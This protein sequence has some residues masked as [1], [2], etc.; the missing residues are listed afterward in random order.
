MAD[1]VEI[2]SQDVQASLVLR[3]SDVDKFT[4]KALLDMPGPRMVFD[5]ETMAEQAL[6]GFAK[7]AVNIEL[8][9]LEPFGLMAEASIPRF[10]DYS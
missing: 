10:E 3:A 5:T 4:W 9:E 1:I 8:L 7:P 6:Q 2:T